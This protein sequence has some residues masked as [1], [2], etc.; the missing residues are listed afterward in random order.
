[1]SLV[2]CHN[3]TPSFT[4]EDGKVY[5]ASSPDEIAMVKFSDRLGLKLL[6][7]D[8]HTMS[9]ELPTG[10]KEKYTILAIFPFSSDTKSMG[11]VVR[12]EETSRVIFYLKG[13]D[14]VLQHKVKRVY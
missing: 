5:Q 14:S 7:R 8:L 10:K 11:I 13:A 6:A 3:V 9:V 12:H 2:L 4:K 1:M